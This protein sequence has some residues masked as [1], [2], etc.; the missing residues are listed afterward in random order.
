MFFKKINYDIYQIILELTFNLSKTKVIISFFKI[1]LNGIYTYFTNN[2][3]SMGTLSSP[4]VRQFNKQIFGQIVLTPHQ[5]VE[6]SV[7]P[8]GAVY[9]YSDQFT[10]ADVNFKAY[11]F[12][13]YKPALL[14]TEKKQYAIFSAFN[15]NQQNVQNGTLRSF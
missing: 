2:I 12:T 1:S 14:T 3:A 15:Q 10:I 4:Q 8:F 13:R 11:F 9:T 7:I 5:T 6:N